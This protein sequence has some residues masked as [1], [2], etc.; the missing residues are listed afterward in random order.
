MEEGEPSLMRSLFPEEDKEC[1]DGKGRLEIFKKIEKVSKLEEVIKNNSLFFEDKEK[2][3]MDYFAEN[4]LDDTKEEYRRYMEEVDDYLNPYL[5]GGSS[6]AYAGVAENKRTAVVRPGPQV[7][8]LRR[9]CFSGKG[10]ESADVGS[11]E[12]SSNSSI[13][14]CLGSFYDDGG[15]CEE[16]RMSEAE[17]EG[18][19]MKEKILDDGYVLF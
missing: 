4:Y 18:L 8:D 7:R 13:N 9:F 5:G 12:S 2:N 11:E 3:L 10:S 16:P 15:G 19:R 1:N 6:K 14:E 17:L